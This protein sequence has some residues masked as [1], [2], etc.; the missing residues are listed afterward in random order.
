M[1]QG[2]GKLVEEDPEIGSRKRTSQSANMALEEGLSHNE[3]E[4]Q[5]TFFAMSKLVKVLCDDYLE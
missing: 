1:N 4:F 5:K 2:E 3:I